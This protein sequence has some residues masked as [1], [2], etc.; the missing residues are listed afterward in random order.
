MTEDKDRLKDAALALAVTE[1]RGRLLHRR[2]QLSP[3]P[4]QLEA[5]QALQQ[6][7]EAQRRAL[8]DIRRSIPECEGK[9]Y[10]W[11][12]DY[13]AEKLPVPFADCL[14]MPQG[15]YSEQDD[16]EDHSG[17][18]LT[19]AGRSITVMDALRQYFSMSDYIVLYAD[20]KRMKANLNAPLSMRAILC[21]EES[22][23][24]PE[25]DSANHRPMPQETDNSYEY[26]RLQR[27]AAAISDHL[28]EQIAAFD[29]RN[30]SLERLL[31]AAANRGPFT[32]QESWLMGMTDDDDYYTTA[33]YREYRQNEMKEK[34]RDEI[35]RLE[36]Q[37][38]QMRKQAA[39]AQED[40]QHYEL[41]RSL[42]RQREGFIL[43]LIRCGYVFYLQQQFVGLVVIAR[44]E[45]LFH[46]RHRGTLSPY[47]IY[48]SVLEAKT[49]GYVMPDPLPLMDFIL[50][51]YG[52]GLKPYSV[53]A[54]RPKNASDEFWRC[55]AE[56]RFAFFAEEK[57][58]GV[59]KVMK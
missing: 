23:A 29:R 39:R 54:S 25:K 38:Q 19:R 47:D 42:A 7:H 16:F 36:Y 33:L 44:P 5:L 51:K 59:P 31:N 49:S 43:K 37:M 6:K 17:G 50:Q 40:R 56:K 48:G 58:E 26:R 12:I 10:W 35:S 15:I 9:A 34:A 18:F 20:R 52:V 4:G 28:S 41:N 27:E 14:S 57:M 11:D 8:N 2:F 53:L 55:W 24:A 46:L 22:A 32:D 21:C 1:L 30:D 45:M 13:K 3:A